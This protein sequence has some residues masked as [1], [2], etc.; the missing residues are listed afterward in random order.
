G[1]DCGGAPSKRTGRPTRIWQLRGEREEGASRPQPSHRGD[2]HHRRKTGCK[3]Q[4]RQGADGK[5]GSRRDG[6]DAG[7][8]R[9]MPSEES[10]RDGGAIWLREGSK[11]AR[12]WRT[13]S[14]ASRDR[15]CR[16]TSSGKSKGTPSI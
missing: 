5:A 10:G 16:R 15:L 9:V 6:S 11:K 1:P 13:R 2:H 4:A 8:G 12:P 3:L 14:A 7:R